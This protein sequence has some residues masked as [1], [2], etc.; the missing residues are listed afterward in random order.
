MDK[1]KLVKVLPPEDMKGF[2]EF[3][4]GQPQDTNFL[5]RGVAGNKKEVSFEH[6]TF[7]TNDSERLLRIKNLLTEKLPFSSKFQQSEALLKEQDEELIVIRKKIFEISD[8][9]NSPYRR[10]LSELF[11]SFFGPPKT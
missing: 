8:K 10:S 9:K 5:P 2:E 7:L 4:E 6:F 3:V 11:D 1:K